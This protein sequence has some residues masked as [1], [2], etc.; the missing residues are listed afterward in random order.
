LEKELEVRLR[1]QAATAIRK[2]AKMT[3]RSADSVVSD[4][5]RAYLWLLREQARGHRIVSMPPEGGSLEDEA[6]LDMLVQDTDI[7]EQYFRKLEWWPEH[8][9]HAAGHAT[10]VK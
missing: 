9:G 4:A 7:A 6:E 5:L 8:R 10:Q 3:K 1:D 2:M